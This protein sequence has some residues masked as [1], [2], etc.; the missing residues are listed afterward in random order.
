MPA[1]WITLGQLL[2]LHSFLYL[3]IQWGLKWSAF[4]ICLC[5]PPPTR[6][7]SFIFQTVQ[8][9][10]VSYLH[11]SRTKISLYEYQCANWREGFQAATLHSVVLSAHLFLCVLGGRKNGHCLGRLALLRLLQ[12]L[13]LVQAIFGCEFSGSAN[14]LLRSRRVSFDAQCNLNCEPQSNRSYISGHG[15]ITTRGK[16]EIDHTAS[17]EW[18]GCC[19]LVEGYSQ[20][21]NEVMVV[22]SIQIYC[23]I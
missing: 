9:V 4:S 11:A 15:L 5:L 2:Y 13:F 22:V 10:R 7:A 23:L 18:N 19:C 3:K 1:I 17:G 14:C 12:Y 8:E 6:F 16:L 21:E 20:D